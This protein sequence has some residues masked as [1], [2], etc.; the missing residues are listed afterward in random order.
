[1]YK[2]I[3]IASIG[4]GSGHNMAAYALAETAC[5]N[6]PGSD[7]RVIDFLSY[8]K[9]LKDRLRRAFYFS[10]I[11]YAPRAYH[12]FYQ[13]L[14]NNKWF[15]TLL[16]KPYL[17]KMGKFV[18]SFSPDLIISTHAFCAM[19]SLELQKRHPEIKTTWGVLTDFMDDTYWNACRLDRFFVATDELK[20]RM[21]MSGIPET[22]IEVRPFPVRQVFHRKGDR[23]ELCRKIDQNLRPDIYTVLV[24]G[25]GEGLGRIEDVVAVLKELPVQCLIVTGRNERLRERLDRLKQDYPSLFVFGYIDNMHE[26]MDMSDLCVTKPG[27]ATVAECMVKGLPM[28]TC[29]PPLPGPETE[30]MTFLS[31]KKLAELCPT[32]DSLRAAVR[33]RID[34]KKL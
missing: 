22:S 34:D 26:M 16:F 6:F 17:K 30:N 10:T 13:T 1:M 23:E 4:Y 12:F 31:S 21:I 24:L 18:D 28:I 7:I 29:R 8:D 27:G 32:M 2:K 20:D 11:R 15:V 9:G 14:S 33:K 19:A 3:L 25:G 5:H